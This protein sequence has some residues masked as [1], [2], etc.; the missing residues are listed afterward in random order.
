M[1]ANLKYNTH[2]MPKSKAHSEGMKTIQADIRNVRGSI[3]KEDRIYQRKKDRNLRIRMVYPD[4]INIQK[5][6][7]LLIH[8]QGSAWFEQDLNGKILDFKS[9]ILA[10]YALAIVEYVPLPDAVFPSQVED[11]KMA[12]RYLDSHAKEMDLDPDKFIISGD[13]SGG[14]TALMAWATWNSQQLD[15]ANTDLPDLK[16]CIDLYG[17][18]DFVTIT[19]QT[20]A[21]D[22]TQPTS[23]DGL[24]IGGKAPDEYPE[25]AKRA[26]V[27]YYLKDSNILA[28]LLIIHGNKD[29]LVPFEQSV[30]LY[31]FCK[32][33]NIQADFY[34]VD[35]ADHGGPTFYTSEVIQ[36]ILDFMNKCLK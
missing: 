21:T 17:V 6:F 20:S 25:D 22:H 13:S 24:L 2:T 9:L 19:K 1:V 26:S 34:C 30:E 23:P 4:A 16:A 33:K 3:I 32:Q 14:H 11:I 10:G 31:D 18:Y 15:A 28:P 27:P 36:I 8:V 7:P 29:T 5:P 35:G 12:I